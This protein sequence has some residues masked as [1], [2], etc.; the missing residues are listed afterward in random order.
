MTIPILPGPDSIAYE[1]CERRAVDGP[2]RETT[3]GVHVE[4]PPDVALVVTV[5]V[6][7]P[8]RFT[9]RTWTV[10]GAVRVVTVTVKPFGAAP[11]VYRP[12]DLPIPSHAF[13]EFWP[14][15]TEME[16]VF[17]YLGAPHPLA[18]YVIGYK[19]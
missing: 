11:I 3:I 1:G 4:S 5:H 19:D 17:R 13:G 16:L 9:F 12:D 6:K 10:D 14:A 2:R 8:Q 15:G 18:V 7:F